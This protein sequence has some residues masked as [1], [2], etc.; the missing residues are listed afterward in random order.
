VRRISE[1]LRLRAEGV[2]VRD[3]AASCGA[4]KTTVYEYLARAEAAGVGWPLPEGLD[5]E[6]VE[7]LLLPPPSGELAARRPV[8]EWAAVHRE[9]KGKKHVT[10]RL[11]WLEWR[12]AHPD[13]WGYSQFCWHYQ[14]WLATKDV[15]MRLEYAAGERMFVDFSGDK[16]AWVDGQSGEV[17]AAEVFVA[18]LGCSGMLYA[19]ATRGQDLDSWLWAHVHA[20]EAYGGAAAVTVPDNLKSGV[21]KACFY[22]PE[23]NPSYAELAAHYRTAVLPTR[24][25]RPRDKAAVEAGVLSVERWVLAPLRHRRFFSLAELNAA[26]AEKVAGLNARPFRGG[27]TSR[28]ELFAAVERPALRPLPTQRWELAEWKKATVNIDYHVEWDGRF[29]SVPYRLVRQRLEVRATP[30]TVEVFQASKR[31]ASHARE[32]GRRRYITDPAHMPASHRAHA[33]WTP[34]R[35]IHWA[36]TVSPSMAALVEKLLE[37]RPHPEHA[38]RA[39]LGLMSLTRRY[40]NDR[41]G[42]AAER[43]LVSGAISYSSVKSILA[44]GLDRV[45]LQPPGPTPPP[46]QHD[47][48][49]GPAYYRD[50]QQEA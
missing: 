45:A 50:N 33:E 11:L 9:L 41:A 42:A 25:Y 8:P 27:P 32:Y 35:L 5:D 47:N 31:V 10:L 18:V 29:Y 6:A 4:S 43:A 48:L 28:G 49:R 26:M 13:G 21:S 34:S 30:S 2:S 12:E 3:I 39:C 15:V 36:A 24:T 22:D 19:E 16:A 17:H 44:E 23:I 20:W 46:P 1:I 14:R 37:S 40:G 7:D 38:Y